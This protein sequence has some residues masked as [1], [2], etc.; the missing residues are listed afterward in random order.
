L[1]HL[2]NKYELSDT[3]GNEKLKKSL[4]NRLKFAAEMAKKDLTDYETTAIHIDNISD[5][6]GE[7]I[8]EIINFSKSEF[9]EL[10]SKKVMDSINLCKDA[11][12]ES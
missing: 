10:I 4:L 11:L 7:D 5:D 1:P 6:D 12:K 3:L 9:E 8:E 2:E